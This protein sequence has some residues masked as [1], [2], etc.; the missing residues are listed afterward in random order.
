MTDPQVASAEAHGELSVGDVITGLNKVAT[1]ERSLPQDISWRLE[2]LESEARGV[3]YWSATAQLEM[4]SPQQGGETN[5]GEEIS[6]EELPQLGSETLEAELKLVWPDAYSEDPVMWRFQADLE[7]E[8]LAEV[9]HE[10]VQR[11]LAWGFDETQECWWVALERARGISLAEVIKSRALSPPDARI[12]FSSL[13]DALRACH[14]AQVSHRHIDPAYIILTQ[15]SAKLTRFQWAEEV[16]A[17]EISAATAL[18]RGGAAREDGPRYDLLPPEW[19]DGVDGDASADLYSFGASLLRALSPEGSTWRDAPPE[20]QAVIAVL[21]HLDPDARGDAD[22]LCAL[23][24]RAATSYLYRGTADEEPRRLML[25]QVVDLI[26]KDEV[27]WHMLGA[28]EQ[29]I[30]MGRD[31]PLSASD[32]EAELRSW[33]E[34]AEV[35]EAIDRAKRAQPTQDRDRSTQK[36]LELLKREE[37]LNEKERALREALKAR[38]AELKKQS[39]TLKAHQERAVKRERELREELSRERD[40]AERALAEAEQLRANAQDEYQAAREARALAGSTL[41]AQD[42][43]MAETQAGLR[44]SYEQLKQRAQRLKTIEAQARE[45]RQELLGREEKLNQRQSELSELENQLSQQ[46]LELEESLREAQRAAAQ[47]RVDAQEASERKERAARH[48][49]AAASAKER[50]EIERSEWREELERGQRE[51]SRRRAD[52]Q[53]KLEDAER[54][55]SLAASERA[56]AEAERSTAKRML[57]EAETVAEQLVKERAKVDADLETVKRER[58][59]I[60]REQSKLLEGQ[61]ELIDQTRQITFRERAVRQSE[62]ETKRKEALADE[63]VAEAESR[64]AALV[65]REERVEAGKLALLNERRELEEE[66]RGFER[67][68]AQLSGTFLALTEGR[69]ARGEDGEPLPAGE[70]SEVQVEGTTLR[71]RYCAP[72]RAL[73]GSQREEG[74]DHDGRAEE[75]PR[76]LVEMT[77]GYWLSE[78][79]VT[80]R[81]W[82]MVMGPKE[83]DFEGD[84]LPADRISWLEATRFCNQLSRAFGLSPAYQI[85]R[86]ARPVI[87]WNMDSTGYRLPTEAEWEHA[88][89]AGGIHGGSLPGDDPLSEQ[90]WYGKNAQ[91]RPQR[92]GQ[93]LSNRWGLHDLVGNV[94]EW[95][96]DEWRRDTYRSRVRDGSRAVINP[97]HYQE[98]LTPRVIRGGAFYDLSSTCRLSVR[99]GQEVDNGYGVGLRLCLPLI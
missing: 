90:G 74:V 5:T 35:V 13:A 41:A 77:R 39:A 47:A 93:K 25:Y 73:H 80:Q 72:G 20:L 42:A 31:E 15:K 29:R 60:K 95:C 51:L 83:W 49:E 75:R 52:L 92:V 96:H 71:L 19:L 10:S 82:T 76:H 14:Q 22:G 8:R 43:E 9:Q 2:S 23:L 61:R 18:L 48:E 26:R 88:A 12:L 37:S 64:L 44:E 3:Q 34:F 63:L 46:K 78:T 7:V 38:S 70:V 79:P 6:S 27:A 33:G 87:T 85:E 86:G 58:E 4:S 81:V 28:P 40:R 16:R 91:R 69:V 97:V 53:S 56:S 57:T 68:R 98:Q 30:R 1:S 99:P 55:A 17:G 59:L 67:D 66:R 54:D 94:W 62:E 21:M 45:K 50:L 36:A 32:H 89:R 11:V 65:E 84:E 24:E